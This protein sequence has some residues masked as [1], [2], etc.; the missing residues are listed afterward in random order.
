MLV[1]S[2]GILRSYLTGDGWE[3]LGVVVFPALVAW[4]LFQ[5]CQ[6]QTHIMSGRK[7][8]KVFQCDI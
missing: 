4:L 5:H 2:L 3:N 6:Y 7:I 8:M 1:R